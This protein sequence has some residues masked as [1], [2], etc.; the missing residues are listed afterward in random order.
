MQIPGTHAILVAD[1]TWPV[2]SVDTP[3]KEKN[4]LFALWLD[5]E[6]DWGMAH[7][8]RTQQNPDPTK[9]C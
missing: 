5:T 7:W 8:S 2:C 3:P 1:A 6:G 9:K 4:D